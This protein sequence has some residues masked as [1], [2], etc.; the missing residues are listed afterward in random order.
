MTLELLAVDPPHKDDGHRRGPASPLSSC[1][2][3]VVEDDRQ[4][5][6]EPFA[7]LSG[8]EDHYSRTNCS[9]ETSLRYRPAM[10]RGQ[11]ASHSQPLVTYHEPYLP[12]SPLLVAR[13]GW[14]K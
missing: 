2:C 14:G 12:M 7:V 8:G 1:V 13:F 4:I 5:V 9:P 3:G 11:L 6:C 10:P